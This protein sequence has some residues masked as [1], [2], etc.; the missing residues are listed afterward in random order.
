MLVFEKRRDFPF[1]NRAHVNAMFEVEAIYYLL[2]LCCTTFVPLS[3]VSGT[4][5]QHD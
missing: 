5:S 1:K 2:V 4:Q 3:H